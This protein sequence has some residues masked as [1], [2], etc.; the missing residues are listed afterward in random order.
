MK[1]QDKSRFCDLKAKS[2]LWPSGTTA[3][4]LRRLIYAEKIVAPFDSNP[5]YIKRKTSY[6]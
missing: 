3:I 2:G 4:S 6:D 5:L 1:G